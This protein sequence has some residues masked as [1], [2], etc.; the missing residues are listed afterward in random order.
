MWKSLGQ[1]ILRFRW[2]LLIL[3]IALTAFMGYQA[4]KVELSYEFARAIPTDNPKYKAYQDFKSKFGEDGNLLVI[5]LQTPDL[6]NEKIFNAYCT[7]QRTLKK[8]SKVEDIISIPSAVNLVKVPETEKLKAQNIFRDT[9]LSQAEI[10]SCKNVFLSLPFYRGL[11]YNPQTHAWLMG[12]RINKEVMNSKKRNAVVENI[13]N[14][15]NDFGKK[16]NLE[17]Y[18]SGLP[19]VRTIMTT[20]VAKEMQLFLLISVILSAIILLFFFRSVSAMLLSLSVV[21]IGVLWSLGTMHLF[22]YK[23]TLL[24]ALIPPLVVVIGIPNC[25]YFLNKYHT[26]YNDTG[27]KREALITMVSRM[28]IVTLFCNLTAAIGFAVFAFTKSQVLKEFGVVA[29]IN[30]ISLF[31]ISLILIPVTLSFLSVPKSKHTKYLESMRLNRWLNRLE[32]WSLGHRNL[33]YTATVLIV[34][35]SIVGL[36]R[37]QSVGYIVDDLPKTDK[38]YTDLK[39][40][41][42][43]FKG[44]MP[45]EI[46]VDTKKKYGVSRNFGNLLKID[47]LS[48]YIQTIPDIARPLSITEGLKFAKQAF[49]EG[50]SNNYSMPAEYDLPALAQYLSFKGDSSGTK[51]SFSKLVASFMDS[52]RQEARISVNMADVGSKRLPMILDSIQRR[53]SQLFDSTKYEVELTGTSV[54]F[55]E[56]SRYIIDGLKESIM[57]AFLLIALCMLYLFRSFRILL[58]SLIPN[59]IPLVITAGVMGWT[60]VALKPS[61]VLVFSVALGIA[62]DVTIRF[63][64]NYKQELPNHNY[65]SKETVIATIHSTGISIIYTSMV[66][67]AG[68]IIFCFSGFGGTKALGWLTS[69]TLVSAT[70]TNLVLLPALLITIGKDKK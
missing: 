23:I 7:L 42:K 60:G 46:L 65:N 14:I 57:W 10:D 8:A 68:F 41:E 62:I 63:L 15:A 70:I 56:G 33:I 4:S 1:F 48:R 20:R 53:V 3:V 49:F 11:L 34:A 66:L 25:I 40:F 50:D 51:N 16:T 64:V 30:I 61:T 47:S 12:V 28:G 55:L 17:V 38:L 2:P 13:V 59:I 67:I 24:T 44:V 52:A 43:N 27:E 35:V 6:F 9:T 29:G 39:F 45:L 36:F 19:L 18:L 22:H 69:L 31:F 54:T 58:C 5:G 26:A 32:T 37:L 21:I